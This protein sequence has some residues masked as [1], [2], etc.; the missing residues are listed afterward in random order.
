M[1]FLLILTVTLL[2][3]QVTPAM[4]CWNKLGRCRETCEQNEVFHIMCKNEGMCCIS[5][6][7]LP[8]RN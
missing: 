4:K 1:K 3:A 7:H 2:L 5:P 6:K 8:A